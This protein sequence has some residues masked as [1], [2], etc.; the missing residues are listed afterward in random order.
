MPDRLSRQAGAVAAWARPDGRVQVEVAST[1][2]SAGTD[3]AIRCETTYLVSGDGRIRVDA[4]LDM[5]RGF[6]HVPRVGIGLVLPAGFEAL[7]WFGRGPGENYC[8]RKEHTPVARYT[9]TVSAQHFPF[10][11]PSECGGHEDVRWVKLAA[12]DGRAL[13]VESP[14]PFHFDAHH[15][16]VEDYW[17]AKHDHELVRRPETFLNLDCRHAGIGDNMSWSTVMDEKHLVPASSY[18]FRFDLRVL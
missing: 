16:S 3:K 18:R 6:R 12:A 15:S 7:E 8:D 10:I 1:L 14:A 2:V 5:D 4:Q 11:P 17:R 13:L 9:S